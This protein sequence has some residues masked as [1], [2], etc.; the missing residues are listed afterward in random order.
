LVV[1]GAFR[2][3]GQSESQNAARADHRT[4]WA[5]QGLVQDPGAES[6]EDEESGVGTWVKNQSENAAS[7]VGDLAKGAAKE[8]TKQGLVAAIRAYAPQALEVFQGLANGIPGISQSL[9]VNRVAMKTR[10]AIR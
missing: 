10:F 7:E 8:A 5:D 1:I 9:P 2:Y 4:K 3:G 6:V